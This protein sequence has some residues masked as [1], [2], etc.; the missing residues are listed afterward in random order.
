[1]DL[2]SGFL[3][4]T[5]SHFIL[6]T[7]P[8]SGWLAGSGSYQRNGTGLSLRCLSWVEVHNGTASYALDQVFEATLDESELVFE[9]RYR[10]Q[11]K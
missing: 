3:G 4:L 9:D 8:E 6:V 1:M 2:D 7:K 10:F 5:D 11:R